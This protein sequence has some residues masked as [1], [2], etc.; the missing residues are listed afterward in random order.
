MVKLPDNK[1]I[2]VDSKVSLVAYEAYI[3]SEDPNIK[4][5]YLK[6]HIDSIKTHIKGLSEKKY[7]HGSS[8]DT[9]D[10]VLLFYAY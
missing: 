1:H 7:Q 3:N 4:S 8:F 10:F 2:I 9:P 6:Q 5:G